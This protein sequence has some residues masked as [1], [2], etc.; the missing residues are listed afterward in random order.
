MDVQLN[1]VNRRKKGILNSKAVRVINFCQ[2]NI[3]KTVLA[4]PRGNMWHIGE[5]RMFLIKDISIYEK[6][7]KCE[8][9]RRICI[10]NRFNNYIFAI[11]S[12][13]I[14]ISSLENHLN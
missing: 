10:H 11:Y 2:E 5:Y 1:K 4:R 12:P 6:K 8:K 7:K 9:L 14:S 3:D 13:K